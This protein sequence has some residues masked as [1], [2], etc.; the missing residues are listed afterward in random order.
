M[1]IVSGDNRPTI[2]L[3]NTR[4]ADEGPSELAPQQLNLDCS[5]INTAPCEEEKGV[6]D[7]EINILTSE[8]QF[9][10]E[11]SQP[12]LKSIDSSSCSPRLA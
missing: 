5:I 7:K 6:L 9:H 12:R 10:F 8:P 11:D 2:G 4:R 3:E 1:T